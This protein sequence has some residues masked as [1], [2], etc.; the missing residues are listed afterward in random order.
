MEKRA[1]SYRGNN[2]R[3]AT[4]D[5]APRTR[6]MRLVRSVYVTKVF[7]AKRPVV[8]LRPVTWIVVEKNAY[9]T[10]NVKPIGKLKG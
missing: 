4:P 2:S 10:K 1:T 3:Q 5:A 8:R 6:R 7:G 9:P